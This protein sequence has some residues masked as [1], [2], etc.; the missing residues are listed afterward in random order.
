MK[1]VTLKKSD[2]KKKNLGNFDKRTKDIECPEL[3]PLCGLLPLSEQPKVEI[4]IT[5]LTK[6]LKGAEDKKQIKEIEKEIEE[7]KD[8]TGIVNIIVRQ[9]ELSEFLLLQ[10]ELNDNIQNLVEGVVAAAIERDK[11][12]SVVGEL[13][14]QS[15]K[16]SKET[17]HRLRFVKAGIKEPEL[18]YTDVIWISQ[19][20]PSVIM[21]L[22]KEIETLTAQGGT[23]KKSI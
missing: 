15:Y 1:K 10:H 7:L 21:R 2:L 9:L 11:V 17:A 19:M 13:L 18:T 22:Y 4:E 14:D 12:Q 8:K 5:E 6:K 20:F 3:N 23:L 16:L